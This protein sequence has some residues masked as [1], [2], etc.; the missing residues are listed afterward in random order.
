MR[1]L[2]KRCILILLD[3]LGDRA[4][5]SLGRQTPLQAA[6]TPNLDKAAF[7]GGCGLMYASHQGL[8]LPSEEA[9]FSIFGYGYNEFPGRGTLEALGAGID[10]E[11]GDVSLLAHFASVE[12]NQHSEFII[13]KKRPE[14]VDS[15]ERKRLVSIVCRS[16]ASGERI[17]FD[18]TSGMDGILTV[19]TPASSYIT[20]SDPMR[21]GVPVLEILPVDKAPD[22]SLAL[23]TASLLNRFFIRLYSALDGDPLNRD[24]AARGLMPVNLVLC[25]RAGGYFKVQPF[26]ERWGLNGLSVSSGL[27]YKGMAAFLGMQHISFSDTD[28]PEKDLEERILA[29]LKSGCNFIHVHTKRIDQAAHTKSPEY[30]RDMIERLD[31][32]F[33]LLFS[34]EGE[35]VLFVITADH[36]TPSIGN[37]IHSSEPVPLLMLGP[38]VRRDRVSSFDEI[39]CASGSL[40]QIQGDRFMYH[41]LNMLDMAKLHGLMDSPVDQPFYPGEG[42]ALRFPEI[43][44]RV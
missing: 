42:R 26:C 41:V 31:R 17:L 20:D 14:G 34:K 4:C 28:D 25:Q 43:E 33:H 23:E 27:M 36:S 1:D 21:Q 11:P 40:G 3:G 18:W 10:L 13:I 19:K 6:N 2:A 29:A 32:A 12:M 30:K 22:T 5:A 8:A 37:M 24:R 44:R 16:A 38:G 15:E 9:H 35:D 7:Y 39:S